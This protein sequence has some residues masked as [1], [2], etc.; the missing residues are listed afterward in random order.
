MAKSLVSI[1]I[2][3][4]SPPDKPISQW[5]ISIGY[6]GQEVWILS[7]SCDVWVGNDKIG[8]W[9]E[10][11]PR[12]RRIYF[13]N[14]GTVVFASNVPSYI[15]FGSGR[16]F[17]APPFGGG[18]GVV[19]PPLIAV[20]PLPTALVGGSI[21]ISRYTTEGNQYPLPRITYIEGAVNAQF[22][23]YTDQSPN[24]LALGRDVS[25]I[26]STG[27]VVCQY[28]TF[29]N[30]VSQAV[31]FLTI[32]SWNYVPVAKQGF[33]P[34]LDTTYYINYSIALTQVAPA[35][36]WVVLLE[37]PQAG[38]GTVALQRANFSNPQSG[39][40][41][42]IWIPMPPHPSTTPSNLVPRYS[43][44]EFSLRL[45]NWIIGVLNQFSVT[46]VYFQQNIAAA[47]SAAA[48][49]LT[50]FAQ[51]NVYDAVLPRTNNFRLVY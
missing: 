2:V 12:W 11:I 31:D 28:N 14:E 10:A 47:G 40:V 35:P 25:A 21:R 7:T 26:L 1:E 39:W 51:A 20:Q 44:I 5:I 8:A 13:L 46:H 18:E 45:P 15:T 43:S 29:N 17:D 30:S 9:R 24:K 19:T 36:M 37:T 48:T 50:G 33:S 41:R 6:A 42:S 34:T 49:A 38:V 32:D 4:T 16:V 23:S 3:K 27:P 22:G